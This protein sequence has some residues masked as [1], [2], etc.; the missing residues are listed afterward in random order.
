M[1]KSAEVRTE[2]MAIGNLVA[3]LQ[4]VVDQLEADWRELHQI[5]RKTAGDLHDLRVRAE[6]LFSDAA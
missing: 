3:E 4:R 1:D 2:P 6:S 5:D